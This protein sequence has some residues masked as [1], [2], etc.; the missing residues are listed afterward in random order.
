MLQA[1]CGIPTNEHYWEKSSKKWVK[2]EDGVA[3]PLSLAV[4]C[5]AQLR[6]VPYSLARI[7]A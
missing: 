5:Q 1:T 3:D 2:A 6:A 7:D 4:R